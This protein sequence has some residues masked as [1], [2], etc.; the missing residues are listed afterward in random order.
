[1]LGGSGGS[2]AVQRA[3]IAWNTSRRGMAEPTRPGLTIET[4]PSARSG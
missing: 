3:D 2:N 4:D 1:M